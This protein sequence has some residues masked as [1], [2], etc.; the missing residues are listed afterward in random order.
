MGATSETSRRAT[1]GAIRNA[2][3]SPVSAAGHSPSGKPD[4]PMIDWF[5]PAHA[6]A[7][8]I[9]VPA[10]AAAPTTSG[11]SGLTSTPSSESVDRMSSSENRSPRQMSSAL[12]VRLEDALKRQLEGRG[13]TLYS[14][15]WKRHTTPAGRSLSLQRASALRS[16]ESGCTGWPTPRVG[17]NGGHG[18]AGRA[19]E[20][21]LEDVA[22]TARGATSNGSSAATA[23]GGLLN[24]AFTRWLQGYPPQWSS[25]AVSATRSAYLLQSRSSLRISIVRRRPDP[26]PSRIRR[27]REAMARA[28]GWRQVL[29][30]DDYDHGPVDW[31]QLHDGT[32]WIRPVPRLATL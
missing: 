12:Q 29:P 8:P 21:R 5:G 24:P 22:Q 23:G 26:W 15:T 31:K 2:I 7:S 17:K 20:A 11:T 6:L 10:S 9:R 19:K 16:S 3:S 14:M 13:S 27:W 4:G 28:D 1:S 30:G 32:I 18:N 25:Y